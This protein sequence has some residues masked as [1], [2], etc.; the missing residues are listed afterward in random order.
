MIF[1]CTY[2]EES[3]HL[4][5]VG[6]GRRGVGVHR[7][8]AEDHLVHVPAPGTPAAASILRGGIEPIGTQLRHLLNSSTKLSKSKFLVEFSLPI[9]CLTAGGDFHVRSVRLPLKH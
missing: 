1:Y 6:V 3:P 5:S 8:A 9:E 7:Q 4:S 2:H